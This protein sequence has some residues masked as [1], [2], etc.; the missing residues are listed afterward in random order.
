MGI[1]LSVVTLLI[2]PPLAIVKG[3]IGDKLGS[4]VT[5]SERRQNMLSAYLSG[6]VLGG[7]SANA[8]FGVWRADPITALLLS[9]V[10]VKEGREA[11]RDE[12]CCATPIPVEGAAHCE[13]DCCS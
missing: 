10:A 4:S 3:R 12:S 13:D 1:G 8:L 2:M 11:W 9:G 7:L 5:K 6:A